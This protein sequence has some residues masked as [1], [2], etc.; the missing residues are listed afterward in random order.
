[1][2]IEEVEMRMLQAKLLSRDALVDYYSK[3]NKRL[4]DALKKIQ[5]CFSVVGRNTRAMT[6][7]RGKLDW[8]N[9]IIKE[10]LEGK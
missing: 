5:D 3:E 8:L 4:R 10:A 9:R 6:I 2:N 7:M 1:M